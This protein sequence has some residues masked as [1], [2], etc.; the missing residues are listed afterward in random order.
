MFD[1]VLLK[2]KRWMLMMRFRCHDVKYF[3]G[4]LGEAM[5]N[6]DEESSRNYCH[7]RIH[8]NIQMICAKHNIRDEDLSLIEDDL[9]DYI[10]GLV[11][12]AYIEEKKKLNMRE[13]VD[14][15]IKIKRV[16][17]LELADNLPTG[18]S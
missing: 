10:N 8:E 11:R 16:D 17:G 2:S 9:N 18:E 15:R 7:S 3:A 5:A 1:T 14:S 12:A 6:E 4:R 13:A